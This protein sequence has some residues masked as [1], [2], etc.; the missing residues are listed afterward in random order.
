[1]AD[2]D[3]KPETIIARTSFMTNLF[4]GSKVMSAFQL[5]RG[6]APSILGIPRRVVPQELL[7]S[8]TERETT[9]ALERVMRSNMQRLVERT[10]LTER[11]DVLVYYKSSKQNEPN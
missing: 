5:V 10:K 1:M 2:K 6:Y 3:A 4:R 11:R 7:D 9:P 8:H